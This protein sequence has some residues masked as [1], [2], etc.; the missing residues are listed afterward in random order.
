MEVIAAAETGGAK[1]SLT[2]FEAAIEKL[3][4]IETMPAVAQQLLQ[5]TSDPDFNMSQLHDLVQTDQVIAAKILR[6]ASSPFYG[7]RPATNLRAALIRIGMRDLRKLVM[8]S[9]MMGSKTTKF[10]EALW[11]YSLKTA[12]LSEA[13]AQLVRTKDLD[14]PFLC[15]LMHD[16]GTI[17]MNQVIG[18]PYRTAIGE[19]CAEAQ[20]DIEFDTYGFDHCDLGVMVAQKWK[21]FEALEH[22]MQHHHDPLVVEELGLSE[23]SQVAVFL[24]SLARQM[25]LGLPEETSELVT[26]LCQRL[27]LSEEELAE[28]EARG[29]ERYNDMYSGLLPSRT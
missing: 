23:A 2:D 25:A 3:D 26:E 4:S 20:R 12:A 27:A 22:V 29:M 6:V 1:V 17:L 13:I 18:K 19:P 14:D 28:C 16:F 11:R 9:A 5:I 24:V 8:A 15:G 21:L 7:S 10:T